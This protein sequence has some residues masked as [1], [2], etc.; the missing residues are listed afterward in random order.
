MA[1]IK[2]APSILSADFAHLGN[3]VQEAVS[4]SAD[5]IHVDVMDGHFVPNLTIGPA[6]VK[7][8]RRM[9]DAVLD[10]HLMIESP[11]KYIAPFADA[12]AS[13]LT[14]HIEVMKDPE[15]VFE[16]IR[17]QNIKVGL[18]LNPRTPFSAVEPYLNQIDLLLIMTVQPG[19]GAQAFMQDQLPKIMHAAT[20]KRQKG[21]SYEIEVDGGI[22]DKTAAA[23]CESG[24]EVLV[25]GNAVFGGGVISDNIRHIRFVGE[26]A[27][28]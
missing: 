9:T 24:A 26:K 5:Y 7:S 10:T 6:V 15:Q 11:E 19:F 3:Q 4:G 28:A 13:I 1:Y 23:V 25:A 17:K 21:L 27:I 18:T 2:I 12:G 20:L 22:S 14:V 8:L 16:L